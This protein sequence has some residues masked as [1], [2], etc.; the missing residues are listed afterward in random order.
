MKKKLSVLSL[1]LVT[2]SLM[3]GCKSKNSLFTPTSSGR[4]YEMLVVVGDAMWDQ[5]AGRALFNVLDTDVPGLPQSERSFRLM[6]CSQDH[7]DAT[8]RLLRNII[9]VNIDDK[10]YTQAKMSVANDAHSAPQLILNIQAP[11]QGSFVDFVTKNKEQILDLFNKAE[12]NRQIAQL[13]TGHS[14][15][16]SAK[17]D[18]LFG[19][20]IWLPSEMLST[21]VSPDFLWAATNTPTGDLNFV[22]YS[23]PF[24][25]DS[26][27][28]QNYFVAKRDSF[29]KANI[30]GAEVGMYM[31]TDS[32]Y[33]STESIEL[34]GEYC[35]VNRGLWR[36]HNDQMG[37]PFVSHSMIDRV[38]GRVITCEVFVYSPDRPKRNLIRRVEASLFTL[39]LPTES[40]K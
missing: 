10:M 39:K 24:E 18:S 22:M 17:V 40:K 2:I 37:G 25:T 9:Q 8:M 16:I 20:D 32:R 38:H 13:E 15:L 33:V 30:P 7:Y 11:D 19:C 34:N 26:T 36:M 29:M 31:M 6:H 35:Q 12:M 1:I 21:K 28:T 3:V 23:Y 27:F 4:P 14:P 5:P